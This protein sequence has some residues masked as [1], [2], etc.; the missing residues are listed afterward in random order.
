M[1]DLI[2]T[3]ARELDAIPEYVENVVR[4]IDEGATI[5]SSPATGRSC[6]ALWMTS[7]CAGWPTG[8]NISG[9]W[10]PGRRRS[11]PP[12]RGR[13][14]SPRSWPPP[15]TPPPPWREVEDPYRPYKQKRRNSRL[16]GSGGAGAT[17]PLAA[18]S[19]PAVDLERAA[20]DYVDPEKGWRRWCRRYL[21]GRVLIF[22]RGDL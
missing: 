20:R 15:L 18:A 7:C 16:H 17:T 3:L 4:L 9:V 22:C 10:P 14:S 12:S 6:T 2:Q 13:A 11:A 21:R 19:G 8:C 5:P 1:N